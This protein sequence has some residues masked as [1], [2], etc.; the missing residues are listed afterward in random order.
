MARRQ[1]RTLGFAFSAIKKWRPKVFA[2]VEKAVE[3]NRDY[4][5]FSS[6][7]ISISGTRAP[8]KSKDELRKQYVLMFEFLIGRDSDRV[9]RE[10]MN[11]WR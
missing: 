8:P 1:R 5:N 10:P 3:T 9:L 11:N 7:A 4:K 6:S 2:D